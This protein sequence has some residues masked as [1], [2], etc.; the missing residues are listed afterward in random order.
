MSGNTVRTPRYYTRSGSARESVAQAPARAL[1]YHR[2]VLKALRFSIAAVFVAFALLQVNDPD[3]V[4][5]L[6]AYGLVA[7]SI[8]APSHFVFAQQLAWLT[9]GVLL[10]L[11]LL[12]LPGFVDYLASGQPDTIFAEMS[13]DLPHVEPAREFLGLVIAGAALAAV[14]Y[15]SLRYGSARHA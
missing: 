10:A 9:A 3:P 1:R 14:R 13:P 5:W 15:Y 2:R 7:A 12:S 11:G 8:A 4:V 6:V